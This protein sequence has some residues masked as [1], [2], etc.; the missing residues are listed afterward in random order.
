MGLCND[1]AVNFLK[2]NNLN[3]IRHPEENVFPLDLIG[4]FRGAR[5]IIGRIDQLVEHPTAPLPGVQSGAAANLSG[6]RTSKLPIAIG[7]DIL[8]SVLGAF[9]GNLGV[10]AAYDGSRK[11]EFMFLNVHRDRANQIA[12]G[13]YVESGEVRWDHL[14]LAKYLFGEGKLYVI[15]EVAKSNEIGV[16]AFRSGNVAIRL[17][18]PTVQAMVGGAVS[19]GIENESTSTLTFKGDKSLAFGF[20]AVE[21]SAG[22]NEQTGELAL[23]YRPVKAGTVLM[24]AAAARPKLAVLDAGGALGSLRHS[25]PASLGE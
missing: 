18:V 6:Q 20:A 23:V 4:E 3:T 25:D 12:I 1:R 5:G 14:I 9:G 10:K 21:L 11:V 13:D 22:E 19:V 7:L 8:G 15:T 2:E 24:H 16:T 17:D